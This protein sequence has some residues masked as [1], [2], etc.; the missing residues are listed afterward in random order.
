MSANSIRCGVFF[1]L[2]ALITFLFCC[3][4]L[5]ALEPRDFEFRHL[6][7]KEG[8]TDDKVRAILKDSH[9][10]MWFGT[11]GG[12]NRYD[13]YQFKVYKKRLNNPNSLSNDIVTAIHEDKSGIIWL[14]T[15]GGLNRFDPATEQFKRYVHNPHDSKSLSHDI[16]VSIAEDKNGILWIGSWGGG[17]IRFDPSNEQFTTY[18]HDSQNTSSISG[19]YVTAVHQARDN[20]YWVMTRFNGLNLFDPSTQT[21]RH[22]PLLGKNEGSEWG[23]NIFHEDDFGTLWLTSRK[24][25]Y[26]INPKAYKLN[27]YTPKSSDELSIK[28]VVA[29]IRGDLW[30]YGSGK[31][32]SLYK[33]DKKKK[34]LIPYSTRENLNVVYGDD[35]GL[36]WIGTMRFGIMLFDQNPPKFNRVTHDP[37]GEKG[38][39]DKQI[40]S[41]SEDDS[42]NFWLGT[43]K[44][45]IH[46]NR[47]TGKF[48]PYQGN[49]KIPAGIRKTSRCWKVLSDSNGKIWFT[50]ED[51][52]IDRLDPVTGNLKNYRHIPADKKSLT[53]DYTIALLGD[54][55][56][57]IWIGT[58]KGLNRYDPDHDWFDRFYIDPS[59]PENPLNNIITIIED[60]NGLLWTGSWYGGLSCFDKTKGQFI[61]SYRH[62]P[63]DSN[64]IISNTVNVIHERRDGRFWVGTSNGLSLFDPETEKF[65]HFTE[66]DGLPNSYVKG[67]LEDDKQRLWISTEKGLSLFNP[68]T[69]VFRNYDIS[70][71]LHSNQFAQGSYT[72]GSSGEF[73]FG[74]MNGFSYFYPERVKDNPYIPPIHITD[75]QLFNK[76]VPIKPDSIL[77]RAISSTD[78]IILSH[79][80]NIFSMEFASL[81]Y[82]FPEKNR[83]RYKLV[84]LDKNWNEVDSKRRYVTYTSL[85]PGEYVFQVQGSNNDGVWNEKGTSLT[86]KILPPW[87]QTWWAWMLYALSGALLFYGVMRLRLRASERQRLLLQEKVDART[88]E[89]RKLSQATENSPASVVVTDKNGTI[90][91]VNQTFCEVT[92]YSADEAIGQNPRILKSGNRSEQYYKE[93]WDTILSGK[94]WRGEFR[95][96]RKNGDKYWE[97]AS[98]SPIMDEEGEITHFVAVKQDTTERKRMEREI[99]AAKEKAEEATRAKSDFLANMSHEIRTPMNAVIGMAHLA[100]KTDLTSK[101]WDYIS[102]IQSSAN[103][104][105]GIINDILDFSK[106][107]AGK[108]EMEEVEFDLSEALD[109]V[110]NVITVKAQ[111]K[112]N[113]EVLFYLDTKVPNLLLGDPLRL[114]QILVNLG[115]NAVKFT[116]RGEIVLMTR[117]K[118]RSDDKI[119]LEFSMRDTGI[120]M[121]EEQQSKLFQSFSQADSS[122][123]RKFGGTGLGLTISKRLIN[124]MGGDIWVESEPGKGTT[125]SFTTN[126]GLGKETGKR[127]FVPS[128]DLRGLKVLVVDDSATSRG[129]L[130]DILE[131]FS[132]EVNLAPSGEEA[133]E[134]IECAE[135]NQ[136]F[137]LV[138]MDWKMPGMD[139]LETS[140]RIKTHKALNKIPAI[141]IVTAYG[142][143]EIIRQADEIGLEGF[144]H[145]PVS[146]SMLFDTIMQALGKG[147]EEPSGIRRKEEKT[148]DEMQSLAGARVLLVEDNEI[149][150][151]VAQEI[152]QNAGLSV[153][154]ANDGQEGVNAALK[155]QYD[156]ILMDIQMPVMDGYTATREI[157]NLKSEIQNVPIIAMTAHAMTGDDQKSI[158][159]G[160][161][162]HITKPIDP[163]QLFATLRKWVKPA[164]ERVSSQPSSVSDSLAD[165]K[166]FDAPVENDLPESLPGFD[167]AAGLGRLMGNKR[168]YRKLLS[169]FGSDYGDVAN[170]IQEALAARDFKHAHGLVHNLKGLAGNLAA[171]ELLF[172]AIEM[173]KLV[174]GDSNKIPSEKFFESKIQ[175]SGNCH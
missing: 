122:I 41:L 60:S 50:S 155:H 56:D 128:R 89:L 133:L 112:E 159:A 164:P 65:K 38:P 147:I 88:A 115:N 26:A 109:N 100:L 49:L 51:Y 165:P 55:D 106:I 131:S 3:D 61:K 90:E 167:I 33:F 85:D 11:W 162:D 44:N 166:K 149:N 117:I 15:I 154:V 141:V 152:L 137:E 45:V 2:F 140:R 53:S 8:L 127:R 77:T 32:S 79:N 67:I 92:G 81:S 47:K 142:R 18:V 52:G 84:G 48:T 101:Q 124:M 136:P 158:T 46:W 7:S 107:E 113:L 24:A 102:K 36:L 116:E 157:R 13:G 83:Y 108:L 121:T 54:K 98:I 10:F 86:I 134:E 34:Q 93:L 73:F 130:R 37:K 104:L 78:R 25:L 43:S 76:S 42:G 96:I 160:M 143:E 6:S 161:N 27:H 35:S 175:K 58:D 74:G 94:I 151:Q 29:G 163:E 174:K 118:S 70:D 17:L 138:L 129:I 39:P 111:E 144:L 82:R 123:T 150:Q 40:L 170:E 75:F 68:E 1:L 153:T 87:W 126:F 156:V 172:A 62:A 14:G 97:S 69:M 59:K 139:G 21:F 64:S 148:A 173:E 5:F 169:D 19:D 12:L 28:G 9:G 31:R 4:P 171:T 22:F 114:N 120:G 146:A 72:K 168:L 103:S 57:T 99:I 23:Q 105:L 80:Q 135:Q 145:K 91:Y 20:R 71:G 95:N 119:T 125:F 30:V 110:A 63:T 16:L 132:F 66:E